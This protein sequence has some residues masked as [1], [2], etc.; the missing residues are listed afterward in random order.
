M[1]VYFFIATVNILLSTIAYTYLR[2]HFQFAKSY[3]FILAFLLLMINTVGCRLLPL[4]TPLF[5]VKISASLSGLWIAFMYYILLLSIGHGFLHILDKLCKLHLPHLKIAVAGFSFVIF[6][7]IWGTYRAFN[8]TIR[9]ETIVTT[10]LPAN[11]NYK[12]AFLTDIHMGQVLG[13][14]YVERLVA[15]VNQQKPDLI[16]IAGDLLDEKQLYLERENTLAPIINMKPTIGTYAA[17]GNHDY[18]DRPELWQQKLEAV[19]VNVLRDKAV[20]ID[21]K[22]KIT[23]I[24][25]WS[26][27]K[28][29][30]SLQ[31]LATNN[32][33]YYS[34]LMDHQPRRIEAAA[35]AGYDLY[36]AGHTH[37]GQ[38]F[39]NRQVTKRM[40]KLDYGRAMFDNMTA[41][42]NN[43]YG[44]WGPP[45]RT[46]IAPEMVIIELKGK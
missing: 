12:I 4:E 24:T 15:R 43:G 32:K 8:P 16:L 20:I 27:D 21:E 37:T 23:G 46:E 33:D 26:R 6:F 30:T 39:P 5:L 19:N 22:I 28:S 7:I 42:T 31:R 17:Y 38:L 2:L 25:D 11:S 35:N 45:V 29:I 9:T 1:R 34:I 40:Y 44:F 14:N 36:L 41:I 10:K 3:G 18:L 13:R